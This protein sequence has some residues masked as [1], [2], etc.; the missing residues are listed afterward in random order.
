MLSEPTPGELSVTEEVWHFREVRPAGFKHLR[1]HVGSNRTQDPWFINVDVNVTSRFAVIHRLLLVVGVAGEPE[2][3]G[4]LLFEERHVDAERGGG[5]D[6]AE[7][8]TADRGQRR[9]AARRRVSVESGLRGTRAAR[10]SRSLGLRGC[11]AQNCNWRQTVCHTN[12]A[13]IIAKRIDLLVV[14]NCVTVAQT[15]I[16]ACVKRVRVRVFRRCVGW[17]AC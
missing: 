7:A 15:K 6:D 11:D 14:L 9:R 2:G 5:A 13:R 16:R 4:V 1:S 3:S 12:S 10:F 8:R 17:T